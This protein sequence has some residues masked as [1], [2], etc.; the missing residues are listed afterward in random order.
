MPATVSRLLQGGFLQRP[1]AW[2]GAVGSVA[3]LR[4]SL[5]RRIPKQAKEDSAPR[6]STS[7]QTQKQADAQYAWKGPRRLGSAKAKKSLRYIPPKPAPV[8]GL[9][10]HDK[11]R[12]MFF[13]DHPFEAFRGIDLVEKDGVR[14][15]S[16]G[17]QG[18]QWT[19]LRQR[20]WNPS[21]DEFV[22]SSRGVLCKA[23]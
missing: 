22:T 14:E 15:S 19:E 9:E 8:K 12:R 10:L 23:G 2:F 16:L 5:T 11:V 18:E 17:P 4:P 13:A 6:A 7:K 1:P 20:S 3:P 21:A